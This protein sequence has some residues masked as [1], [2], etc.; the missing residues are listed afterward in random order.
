LGLQDALTNLLPLIEAE[1]THIARVPHH[2]LGAYYGMMHYHLGWADQ[3]LS[4][5]STSSGKRVRPVIC[6][7]SCMALGERAEQ[8]LPAAAALELVHNFSLVHDDIQ[9]GSHA[10][11]GRRT[12]WDVWGAPHGINVGDG[13]FVLARLALHRLAEREVSANR[14]QAATLAL[15]RA[16]LSLCE[17][18]YFDMT[19]E[20]RLDINL[21]LYLSMIQ[22]KTAALLAAA[23]Q[24]GAI[25]ASDDP[26]LIESYWRFGENLGMAFQIQDDVMGAW[27]DERSTGKPAAI[28]IRD[29]KKTLLVVYALDQAG[30]PAASRHLAG[31]YAQP[32]PLNAQA[33][34]ETLSILE[35]VGARDY[36]ERLA[37]EYYSKALKSLART[38][39]ENEAQA[40]LRELASSLLGREA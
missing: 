33:V 13:L 38:G 3:E 1:L 16:C 28:D 30:D 25:V 32:E 11:R 31:L 37:E 19:F 24:M 14:L 26:A 36:A 34:A 10:R 23:A 20:N 39:I 2:S 8:A 27:G 17:G 22:L 29:K 9:D 15:D 18:Q 6:I 5:V 40:A 21:D 12:V 35:D 7:L 4:P